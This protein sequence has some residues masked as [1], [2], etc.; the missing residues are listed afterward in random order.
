ML[1]E[2]VPLS[3]KAAPLP[4]VASPLTVPELNVLLSPL[5]VRPP[6]ANVPVLLMV[7]PPPF[8]VTKP[9]MEP[10]P[11]REEPAARVSVPD[12]MPFTVRAEAKF[13]VALPA[14]VPLLIVLVEPFTVS[15]PVVNVLRKAVGNGRI[16]MCESVFEFQLRHKG[17]IFLD[18]IIPYSSS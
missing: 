7:L 2:S 1:P 17:A 4:N 10:I 3:A 9:V 11:L 8:I 12:K 6:V 13:C 16:N 18:L 14:I 5:I 15:P